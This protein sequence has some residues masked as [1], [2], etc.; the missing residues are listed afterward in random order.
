MSF[1]VSRGLLLQLHTWHSDVWAEIVMV[2]GAGDEQRAHFLRYDPMGNK[3]WV[4]ST[5]V[6]NI[7]TTKHSLFLSDKERRTGSIHLNE[8]RSGANTRAWCRPVDLA[9]L[10]SRTSPEQY[11]PALHRPRIAI[12]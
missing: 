7:R 3:R 8:G 12:G 11:V 10:P 1:N 6:A 2:T 4:E 5:P 9:A